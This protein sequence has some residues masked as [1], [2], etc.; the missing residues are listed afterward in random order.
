MP[1]MNA[2]ANGTGSSE[3]D[4][5]I[6]Q[7]ECDL[8]GPHHG[9]EEELG[10]RPTDVYMTGILYPVETDEQREEAAAEQDDA[11]EGVAEEE[12]TDN[13]AAV[14]MTSMRRPTSI[15]ISFTL[16]GTYPKI[17]VLVSAGSYKSVDPPEGVERSQQWRRGPV[18]VE[19]ELALFEGLKEYP[20]AP[21]LRV[22][23]RG[24]RT[25]GAMQATVV[26]ATTNEPTDRARSAREEAAFFQVRLAVRPAR[27]AA[28]IPRRPSHAMSLSDDDSRSAALIYRDMREWAVGHT[29]SATWDDDLDPSEVRVAWLP[30]Q[31]VPSVSADGHEMFAR[32]AKKRFKDASQPFRADVLASAPAETLPTLLSVVPDAYDEWLDEQ[33]A[34]VDALRGVGRLDEPGRQ[35]ASQHLTFAKD[36]VRRMRASIARVG[37]DPVVRQAFQLAQRAMQLQDA[38]KARAL[39]NSTS[40]LQWRPFQLGFQLLALDGLGAP[41]QNAVAHPDRAVMDLL[42]FP[43]GGGKTEAYLGLVA[44]VLFHRRLRGDDPGAGAGGA[45]L[46]RYTL[47]LLTVQ[48]FERAARL[49]CACEKLRRDLNTH[50]QA[51]FGTTPFSIGLWVG[52][53]TTP[54][55]IAD[56][57]AAGAQKARQLAR[58]PACASEESLRWDARPSEEKFVVECASPSCELDGQPLPVWTVDEDVYRERPS[59][60]LGTI[61][62]FAQ[63]ALRSETPRFFG[64]DGAAPPDLIIQDELHLISGPLGT[65]TALY[66]SAIDRLCTR[67]DV[68]PKIIGRTATI[69]RAESQVRAL[70]DRAVC[71]F[72]S[73]VLDWYD[74]CFGVLDQRVPGRTYVGVTTSGRSPKFT[75]QG[76]CAS[77]LQAASELPDT[78]GARDPFWTLIAYFNSRRELGGAHVMMH[79]DVHDSID[80][81]SGLHQKPPR[82]LSDELLELTSRVPSEDI[83]AELARLEVRYPSQV[84]D[85]TL[86]TNM[87]SVG[88]DVPRLGL[89]VVNGQ[90][91]S[92]SEY[93]QASSRVGRRATP[94]LIVTVYNNGRPRD[95]SHYESFRTW[96]QMLYRE[97]EATSVTPF[98]PRARDRALHAAVV[99]MVRHLIPKMLTNATLSAADLD[100]AFQFASFLADRASHIPSEADERT[101]VETEA[102]Q[103]ILAWQKRG[104]L[105]SY[106]DDRHPRRS[107][108]VTAEHA[109]RN[110]ATGIRVSEAAR[111]TPNSMREVEPSVELR[112][113]PHLARRTR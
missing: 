68:R 18:R 94:G 66:E 72:P 40:G 61:D 49:I 41:E 62:K 14:S 21:G 82:E 78:A 79:D 47:R 10:A 80:L 19:T 86:A 63:V 3:R 54:N 109:A 42:W 46:M 87:I 37:S 2:K 59:L 102:R 71:Q 25:A 101:S 36:V 103:F 39:K 83:P 58:C 4:L 106:L 29:C 104:V 90:P 88:L 20:A 105:Q 27:D 108:L 89:M 91:K 34:R 98:A 5:L 24:V 70:F 16:S 11:A 110:S 44:F 55:R 9:D 73:P 75:L 113:A 8:V 84:Y 28:F 23:V 12:A 43:T 76:V 38:W 35:Q 95:R 6:H 22:Y 56:A 77:L 97:V 96:H 26:L 31:H 52:Q 64:D 57:R 1:L 92:M 111:A 112:M 45:V 53:S 50:G 48:Q 7:L 15:G 74:S 30:A 51:T 85:V 100:D 107:L 13:G 33:A 32:I 99:I 93:I 17:K 69:R 81:Y 60:L 65:M 67:G